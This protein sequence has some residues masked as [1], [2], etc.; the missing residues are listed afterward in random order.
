MKAMLIPKPETVVSIIDSQKHHDICTKHLR[1]IW[2]HKRTR[3]PNAQIL[4]QANM[5]RWIRW[6][7]NLLVREGIV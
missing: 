4:G 5:E 2:T 1:W 6:S 7:T 3:E